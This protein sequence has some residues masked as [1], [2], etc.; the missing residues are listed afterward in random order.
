MQN[1]ERIIRNK[2]KL[3]QSFCDSDK[4]SFWHRTGNQQQKLI[5]EK[6]IFYIFV[7]QIKN[8]WS[9][10]FAWFRK[11]L[12]TPLLLSEA[13]SIKDLVMARPGR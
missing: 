13:L 10:T 1:L 8:L 4:N 3:N 7:F 5:F 9:T 2:N 6:T 11:C 12:P